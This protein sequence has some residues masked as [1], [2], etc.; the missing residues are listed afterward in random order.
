MEFEASL[1][2]IDSVFLLLLFY[3]VF[4][5][6]QLSAEGTQYGILGEQDALA[7]L[8]ADLRREKQIFGAQPHGR[9]AKVGMRKPVHPI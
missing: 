4:L 6:P 7:Q 1:G 8:E 9:Q 3:F 2:Y 5:K